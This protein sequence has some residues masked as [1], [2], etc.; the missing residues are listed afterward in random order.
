[1]TPISVIAIHDRS[2][3]GDSVKASR[4][5]GTGVAPVISVTRDDRRRCLAGPRNSP[6]ELPIGDTRARTLPPPRCCHGNLRV[7][8]CRRRGG[9]A[10]AT[11]RCIMLTMEHQ[12]RVKTRPRAIIDASTPSWSDRSVSPHVRVPNNT[13]AS[14]ARRERRCSSSPKSSRQLPDG[15]N[16]RTRTRPDLHILILLSARLTV[17][18]MSRPTHRRAHGRAREHHARTWCRR[19]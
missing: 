18:G 3:G 2:L 7:D 4:G 12:G 11:R 8:G 14:D 9:N 15:W 13:S 10:R 17:P 19:P 16:D 5:V 6:R 1:M